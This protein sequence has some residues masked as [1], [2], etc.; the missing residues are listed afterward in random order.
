MTTCISGIDWQPGCLCAHQRFTGS[1]DSVRS[2]RPLPVGAAFAIFF[3]TGPDLV[4]SGHYAG[5]AAVQCA[6]YGLDRR[7][8]T[9]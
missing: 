4:Q 8:H 5:P 3:Y 7:G 6:V 2:P 1:I 9:P